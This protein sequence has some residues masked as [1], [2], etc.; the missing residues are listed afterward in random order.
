MTA[1]GCTSAR[2]FQRSAPVAASKRILPSNIVG[3]A[4]AVVTR[5]N[6]KAHLSLS[7]GVFS[8]VR[9]AGPSGWKRVLAAS[10]QPFQS[11]R[12]EPP[13]VGRCGAAEHWEDGRM[14]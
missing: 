8:L 10:D 2:T 13:A 14:A 1:S 7:F 12:F 9:P 11:A 3:V 6:P 4:K 5:G